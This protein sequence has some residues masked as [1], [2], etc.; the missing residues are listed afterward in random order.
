M[1][2]LVRLVVE[3]GVHTDCD[4]VF[5]TSRDDNVYTVSEFEIEDKTYRLHVAESPHIDGSLALQR[6]TIA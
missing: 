6:R 2:A 4:V 5:D 3:H 1:T